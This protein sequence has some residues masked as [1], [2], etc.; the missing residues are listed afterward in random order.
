MLDM[1]IPFDLVPF[2]RQRSLAV[3]DL[4]IVLWLLVLVLVLLL[5]LFLLLDFAVLCCVCGGGVVIRG[6]DRA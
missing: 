6:Y 5:V 1:F 4:V 3:V 2:F